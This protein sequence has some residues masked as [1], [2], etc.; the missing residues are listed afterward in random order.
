MRRFA[1]VFAPKRD[2][3]KDPSTP[4]ESTGSKVVHRAN[5]LSS[6][7]LSTPILSPSV[8]RGSDT[9]QSSVSSS[10]STSLQTP[11]DVP[12]Y[13]EGAP[14]KSK[15]WINSWLGK[16]P[17]VTKPKLDSGQLNRDW[18]PP[19]PPPLLRPPPPG[20]RSVQ[21]KP[22]QDSD[23]DDS[24]SDSDDD[25]ESVELRP[26]SLSLTPSAVQRS[27]KYLIAHLENAL[28]SRPSA[29]PFVARSPPV[30]PRSSNSGPLPPQNT[31]HSLTLKRRLLNRLTAS[32]HPLSVAEQTAI[33]PFSMKSAPA[34]LPPFT[35]PIDELRPAKSVT[36]SAHSPGLR[37]WIDRPCFEHRFSVWI[38]TPD[39]ISQQ[40]V[41]GTRFAV[42]DLEFSEALEAMID[43]TNHPQTIRDMTP[44]PLS[45]ETSTPV[46]QLDTNSSQTSRKFSVVCVL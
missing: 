8:R 41:S 36:V 44:Q 30:Y 46:V 40:V 37:R 29:H 9:A 21:P 1:S 2:K 42:P 11:D 7:P 16:K 20:I 39:G 27:R 24:S 31:L 28:I 5:T 43:L 6:P 26:K 22:V 19:V 15:S 32:S 17:S 14:T 13:L 23:D 34:L 38:P 33:L 4:Q 3:T 10:G 45:L 25:D 35:Q 12:M 18:Q